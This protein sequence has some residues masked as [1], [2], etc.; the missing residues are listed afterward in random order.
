M[1]W[2][3]YAAECARIDAARRRNEKESAELD[4]RQTRP[5]GHILIDSM[6]APEFIRLEEEHRALVKARADLDERW[7]EMPSPPP[8]E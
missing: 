4:E 8:A 7:P 2:T 5:T 6:A 1:N 3:E